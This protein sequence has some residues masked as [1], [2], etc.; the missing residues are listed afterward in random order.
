MSSFMRAA[1][2]V[3]SLLCLVSTGIGS[4][5]AEAIV[6][7]GHSV[8]LMTISSIDQVCHSLGTVTVNI[9]EPPHG[10]FLEVVQTKAYPNFNALNTRSRCNPSSCRQ[11]KSSTNPQAII[12]GPIR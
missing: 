8:T 9:L 11:R 3:G 4:V 5:H 10:G 12:S 1:F 6:A 7:A 2:G